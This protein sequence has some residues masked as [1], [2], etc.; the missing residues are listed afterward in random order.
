[1]ATQPPP[2]KHKKKNCIVTHF[3]RCSLVIH[4]WASPSLV[5]DT[6]RASQNTL[7]PRKSTHTPQSQDV[8]EDSRRGKKVQQPLM[9]KAQM[10]G[11]SIMEEKTWQRHRN[12][13]P[14][15]MPLSF[16]LCGCYAAMTPW[17]CQI[18]VILKVKL[19]PFSPFQ[20]CDKDVT[21]HECHH[22]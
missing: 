13:T 10:F 8:E 2:I 21:G 12:V 9:R 18:H 15:N 20:S 11:K 7:E 6:W 4:C 14:I 22:I 16:T 3:Y 19:G 1:M 17:Y 5:Q